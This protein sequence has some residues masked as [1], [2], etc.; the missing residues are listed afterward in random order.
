MIK[1][2]EKR[3]ISSIVLIPISIFF[4]IQG[5]IFFI[6]FLSLLFLATSYEWIKMS[7][8]DNLLN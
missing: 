2:F 6:S 1:E 5:S 7:E 8:K 4:I 3:I